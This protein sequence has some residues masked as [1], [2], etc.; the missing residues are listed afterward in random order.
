M[1]TESENNIANTKFRNFSRRLK[2][3]L[4]VGENMFQHITHFGIRLV[5]GTIFIVHGIG[6]LDPIFGNFLSQ[7][8]LPAEMQIPI[9]LAEFVP[10]ILLIS[11]VLSRISSS[12]LSVIMIWAIFY[13]KKASGLTGEMGIEF[14]LI[15]LASNMIVIV[16][17][18]GKISISYLVKKI[19]RFLH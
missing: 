7:S 11:G 18:P 15:L 10:G 14:E 17:G 4:D 12:I 6:K 3:K 13:V 2:L 1:S 19:P 5:L 9:A 16:A 8:G